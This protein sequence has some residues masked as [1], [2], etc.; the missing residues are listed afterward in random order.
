MP[1]KSQTQKEHI[2]QV[3][4]EVA[5]R[6]GRKFD[7]HEKHDLIS[8][9][10]CFAAFAIKKR[11]RFDWLEDVDQACVD[12]VLN[13]AGGETE[14][15]VWRFDLGKKKMAPQ[16][17]ESKLIHWFASGDTGVSS[18]T[19]ACV[20][21]GVPPSKIK[22]CDGPH[23]PSDFGRCYRLVKAV[24]E[25]RRHFPTI[26]KKVPAFR[27]ILKNWDDLVSIYER[28]FASGKS[29]DLYDRIKELRGD[30]PIARQAA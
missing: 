30:R 20:A 17:M 24:P 1:T 22:Y 16:S 7:S 25:I 19:M 4:A 8:V 9:M 28:D 5:R 11:L 10:E 23:D 18:E 14:K 3:V 12:V 27:E 2:E 13:N 21:S 6:L 15:I 29:Q 26:A